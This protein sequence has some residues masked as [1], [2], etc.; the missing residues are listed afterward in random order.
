MYRDVYLQLEKDFYPYAKPSPP[1]DFLTPEWLF[2]QVQTM[3]KDILQEQSSAL[4]PLL[5]R[6]D[7]SEKK[8]REATSEG[9]LDAD[10]LAWA[11][12]RRTAQKVWLR[13]TLG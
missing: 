10:A 4:G 12:L 1:E 11:I 8:A 2:G 3:L 13:R 7:I 6:I 9:R 5:Y